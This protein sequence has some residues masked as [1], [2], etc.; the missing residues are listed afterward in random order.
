MSLRRI[1][2][3]PFISD[4][5]LVMSLVS[6]HV[7]DVRARARMLTMIK[8]THNVMSVPKPAYADRIQDAV[9]HLSKWGERT[10]KAYYDQNMGLTF[11]KND[12]GRVSMKMGLNRPQFHIFNIKSV[13]TLKKHLYNNVIDRSYHKYTGSVC[14][15]MTVGEVLAISKVT[16]ER[17]G[18]IDID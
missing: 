12:N 2:Y 3:D 8:G 6:P 7:S 10:Y 14:V 4:P 17:D 18:V 11:I 9:D 16:V 1:T 13:T 5:Y 15:R